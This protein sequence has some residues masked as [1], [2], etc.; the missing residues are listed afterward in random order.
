[1]IVSTVCFKYKKKTSSFNNFPFNGP[2]AIIITSHLKHPHPPGHR[3]AGEQR[4]WRQGLRRLHRA[5]PPH[6]RLQGRELR[7]RPGAVRPLALS[8]SVINDYN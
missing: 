1:M 7:R 3:G 8:N 2:F 6:R 4:A 5:R